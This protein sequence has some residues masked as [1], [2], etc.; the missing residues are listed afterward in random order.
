MDVSLAEIA[1]PVSVEDATFVAEC[2]AELFAPI[3]GRA[4]ELR[5]YL[6]GTLRANETTMLVIEVDG[7]RAGLI[8]LVRYAMPRYLGFGYEIQ[9]LVVTPAFRRRGV[10][11]RALE[12]AA[13]HCRRDPHARKIVIRTN[14]DEAKRSYAS[15][16][17]ATDMTSF[18]TMLNLLG[19]AS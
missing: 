9:E 4:S 7:A 18:Q 11:R 12:L 6:D 14:V 1:T 17:P 16:W 13:S 3:A 2:L 5:A 19:D 15:V 8:T 10:A